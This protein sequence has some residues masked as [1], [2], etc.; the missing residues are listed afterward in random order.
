MY[1]NYAFEFLE[2]HYMNNQF[3]F[4]AESENFF[5]NYLT[6]T[7]GEA[8]VLISRDKIACY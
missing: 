4:N 6:L 8:L 2:Y 1:R 3:L 7:L 5:S